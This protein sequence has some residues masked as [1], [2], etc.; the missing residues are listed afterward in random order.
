MKKQINKLKYRINLIKVKNIYENLS[1]NGLKILDI[2]LK[3]DDPLMYLLNRLQF[4]LKI[5]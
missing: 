3:F 1:A 2:P 4:L 5:L